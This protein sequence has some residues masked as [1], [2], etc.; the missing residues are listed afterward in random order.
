MFNLTRLLLVTAFL[1]T[2]LLVGCSEV[3]TESSN[4]QLDEFASLDKKPAP[5]SYGNCLSFPVVFAEGYGVTGADVDIFTGLRGTPG[6][7]LFTEPYDATIIDGFP[8]YRNPSVNEWQADW[9]DG[10]LTGEVAIELDWADN[11][12]R[13]T[14]DERSKVRVEVVLFN[15]LAAP[16]TGYNMYSLGG[17]KLDEIFVS[18]TTK[19]AAT[20]ATVYSNV[21]R[22]QVEKLDQ[23]GGTPILEVYNSVCYERYFVDGPSAAYS[24]EVNMGGKCMY[25]FNWNVRNVDASDRT[26]W[27]RLTFS[28]DPQA[29]YTDADNG[30]VYNYARNS[31]ITSL[32]PYD[33][34][35]VN[36]PEVVVY[37]PELALDGYSTV[38][39]IFIESAGGG[40]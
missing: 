4:N 18:N 27:Y 31:K 21:A 17:D 33:L 26:G 16:L 25:G 37:Q 20:L 10:S 2:L 5:D 15:E 13:Q 30:V 28:L 34:F 35:G 39:D 19:Y 22:L 23:Q 38:L 24:A 36:D 11:L 1:A 8:V 14:W 12:T 32:S 40:K 7:E 9:A 6:F 3:P 29:T